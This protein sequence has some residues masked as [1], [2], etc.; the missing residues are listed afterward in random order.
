MPR[1][2]DNT[3]VDPAYYRSQ[4]AKDISERELSEWIIDRLRLAGF[5]LIYHTQSSVGSETGF[6][7]IEA[8]KMGGPLLCIEVKRED[9]KLTAGRIIPKSGRWLPG[10]D[11]WLATLASCPGVRARVVRPSQWLNGDF[12]RWLTEEA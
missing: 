7:D 10:Q 9:G 8:A 11:E 1:H 6:P 4:Q 5:S 12:E 2:I 3:P